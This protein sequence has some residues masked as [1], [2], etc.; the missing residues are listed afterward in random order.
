MS[1]QA[2]PSPCTLV[3][4]LDRRT[5]ICIGCGRLANEIAE[6]ASAPR[7]RQLEIVANAKARL[8]GLS[9]L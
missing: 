5:G 3:C 2:V 1:K 8:A 9:A 4:T 7:A 6:W